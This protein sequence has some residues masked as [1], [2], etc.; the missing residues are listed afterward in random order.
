MKNN[1]CFHKMIK[2][3]T[4]LHLTS[5]TQCFISLNAN[6]GM[7]HDIIIHLTMMIYIANTTL[8]LYTV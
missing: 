6:Q 3:L 1:L 5:E 8:I 2:N 7:T 4:K